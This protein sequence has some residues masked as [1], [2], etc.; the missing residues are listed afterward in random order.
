MFPFLR[1]L[2]LFFDSKLTWN[3]HIHYLKFTGYQKH[4]PLK[5]LSQNY[6]SQRT[7]VFSIYKTLIVSKLNYSFPAY[8]CAMKN[9]LTILDTIQ[10]KIL[11]IATKTYSTPYI[12]TYIQKPTNYLFHFTE[13]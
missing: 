10:N 5:I 4:K 8:S 11:R 6:D 2:G 9:L 13:N 12:I 7:F 3:V 1:H